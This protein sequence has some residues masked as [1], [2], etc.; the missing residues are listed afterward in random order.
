MKKRYTLTLEREINSVEEYNPEQFLEDI[1]YW[2]Q[3]Q[4]EQGETEGSLM[5]ESDLLP[6]NWK[7][8]IKYEEDNE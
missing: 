6:G 3:L 8:E 5:K 2:I 4:I 1:E 7:F